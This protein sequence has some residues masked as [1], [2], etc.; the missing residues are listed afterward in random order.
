MSKLTTLAVITLLVAC[1][2]APQPQTDLDGLKAMRDVVQ[3]RLDTRDP[4]TIATLYAENGSV[5]PPN[6]DIVKGRAAIEAFWVEFLSSGISVNVTDTN[7]HASGDVGYK[8]GTYTIASAYGELLDEGKYVEVWHYMDGKWQMMYD[9]FSS[10][11]PLSAPA[12]VDEAQVMDE[13]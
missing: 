10:N 13:D 2:E 11:R 7:V 4:A 1:A 9:M 5:L 8:V 6:G 12:R 3:A